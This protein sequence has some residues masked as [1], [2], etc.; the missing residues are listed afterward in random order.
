MRRTTEYG[1]RRGSNDPPGETRD[2]DKRSFERRCGEQDRRSGLDRRGAGAL[3]PQRN[4]DPRP[5]G[6]RD[7]RE[8]R[9]CQDRR[10]YRG[11]AESGRFVYLTLE[12]ISVLLS[13]IDD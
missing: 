9:D 11:E 3:P 1:D 10:L 4:Q 6:F 13:D 8:R 7:F 2:G 5:Y 12:E